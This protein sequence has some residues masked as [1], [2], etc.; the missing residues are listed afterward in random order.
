MP[1]RAGTGAD[2]ADVVVGAVGVLKA[3][4]NR[5]ALSIPAIRTVG[6]AVGV[7]CISDVGVVGNRPRKLVLRP[8]LKL[9]S[10]LQSI[11]E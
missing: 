2:A 1:E 11:Y 6:V 8:L 7:I 3:R 5:R 4:M 9:I 10:L